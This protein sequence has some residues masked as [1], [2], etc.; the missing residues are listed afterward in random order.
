MKKPFRLALFSLSLLLILSSCSA[1][2]STNVIKAYPPLHYNIEVLVLDLEDEI[3]SGAEHL[4]TIKVGDSGFS[5][6]CSYDVVIDHAS[7]EARKV[8][9]DAIKIVKHK[10]PDYIWSSCHRITAEVLKL[11][12]Q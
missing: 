1:K 2:V 6:N 3:P 4:G 12:D 8:G 10:K 7:L 9:G 5:T 11:K